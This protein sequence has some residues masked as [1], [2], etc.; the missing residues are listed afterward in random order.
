MHAH[1]QH[2]PMELFQVCISCVSSENSMREHFLSTILFPLYARC[3]LLCSSHMPYNSSL[4]AMTLTGRNCRS[5]KWVNIRS[6]IKMGRT[7]G[8]VSSRNVKM[9]P[10]SSLLCDLLWLPS[11]SRHAR[12]GQGRVLRTALVWVASGIL[13]ESYLNLNELILTF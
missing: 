11:Q 1:R 4:G 9:R 13:Q 6:R 2:S 10:L 8:S 7:F 5:K 12:Q 3:S